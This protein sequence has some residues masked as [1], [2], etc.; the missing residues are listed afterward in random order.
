MAFV[1]IDV[2]LSEAVATVT[3]NRPDRLNAL[4]SR[5]A[6]EL[7]QAFVELPRN[8]ARVMVL[9]GAGRAFCSGAD[10]DDA[11]RNPEFL[12]GHL[13][14]GADLEKIFNPMLERLYAMPIP[15]VAK[16][17]GVAAG[18]G[19]SLALAA[20][21]VVAARSANFLQ[22]FANIG[23]V[24]DMGATWLLPRLVGKARATAMMML[25]EPITATQAEDW[26]MVYRAVED[27]ALDAVSTEIARKLAAGPTAAFALI[28]HGVRQCLELPL[29]EALAVE[30]EGQ[31]AAAATADFPE[32]LSAFLEKRR[33][34][35]SGR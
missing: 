7:S 1:D 26:G 10:L 14:G 9:T 3:I 31:R 30:S 35:F 28:R 22:A 16:V 12:N 5:T 4:L 17:N 8:G 20:D 6:D 21:I 18:A 15:V 24:P 25:A 32:G 27:E 23:L 13:D 11:S 34:R 19:A 29:S 2:D 33:P